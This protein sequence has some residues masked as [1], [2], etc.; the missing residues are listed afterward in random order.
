MK[1][2]LKSAH[3]SRW[4]LYFFC[5]CLFTFS[6][7]SELFSS[8]LN[9]DREEMRGRIFLFQLKRVEI[10]RARNSPSWL[11]GM[12]SINL[13]ALFKTVQYTH[14]RLK[15]N[16][17]NIFPSIEKDASTA[18]VRIREYIFIYS[19]WRHRAQSS[20]F[21]LTNPFITHFLDISPV[22]KKIKIKKKTWNFG[23]WGG[24]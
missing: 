9:A 12:C 20:I 8:C 15:K 17:K 19:L 1:L 2:K 5:P 23:G 11:G 18:V 16:V 4:N 21:T 13:I 7:S 6:N 14:L 10:Y 3:N 24:L 22:W